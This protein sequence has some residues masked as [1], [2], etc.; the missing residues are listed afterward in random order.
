MWVLVDAERKF[1]VLF[2]PGVVLITM[3]E[4]SWALSLLAMAQMVA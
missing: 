3:S 1:Y 4:Q 2:R